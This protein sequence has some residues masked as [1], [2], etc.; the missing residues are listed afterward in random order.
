MIERGLV[1]REEIEAGKVSAAAQGRRHAD[2]TRTSVDAGDPAR[3]PDRTRA[4][5]ACDVCG[6]RDRA[7]E[8]YPPGDA[9][10]AA[11]ICPRASRH[12]RAQPR[13]PRVSRSQL[14][15]HAAKTSNGSTPCASTGRNC[16]A[17]TPIRRSASPSTPGNPI[18]SALMDLTPQQAMRAAV[19]VPGVP[20]DE[21][22]PVFREP[23]EARAFAMALAL[24][25]AGVFTWKEWAERWA[26]RSS[27][28][29][30]PAIPIPA[31][32]ITSTG[33]PRWKPGRRQGRHH[34]RVLHRY[35]DAWDHAADRTPHGEPIELMPEDFGYARRSSIDGRRLPLP[36]NRLGLPQSVPVYSDREMNGHA[37][38]SP[39]ARNSARMFGGDRVG[40]A[41]P[42]HQ[43]RPDTPQGLEAGQIH[44]WP[45]VLTIAVEEQ[46]PAQRFSTGRSARFA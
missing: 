16:G 20:R 43:G 28:R 15:R 36:A 39:A 3:R 21:D 13:L 44:L 17:R 4:E 24:H 25:E 40:P 31:R 22:G 18:W 29:R 23:W 41:Q 19:A 14:A 37:R 1:T 12:H 38:R 8:G 2:R 45:A 9:Y 46:N 30:P 26:R 27:A 35:R 7:D 11:A 34:I 5:A 6:R 42:S 32:P 33:S 10:A